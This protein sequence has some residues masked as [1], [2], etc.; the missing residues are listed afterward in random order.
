MGKIIDINLFINDLHDRDIELI[1]LDKFIPFNQKGQTCKL[2]AG[3][4]IQNYLYVSKFNSME[5][6]P[7]HK[8]RQTFN[9]SL[10]QRAKELIDSKVGEVYG[11]EQVKKVFEYNRFEV[12]SFRIYE[13]I[14]YINLIRDSLKN[15]CPVIVFF[16]V[17]P[18]RE[19]IQNNGSPSLLNGR[20]E[21]AAVVVGIYKENDEYR[22][23]YSQW[24]GFYE[25]SV[26]DLFK[27]TSQLKIDKNSED[28]KKFD[29]IPF[30][31][32][33]SAWISDQ[34]V[35]DTLEIFYEDMPVKKFLFSTLHTFF[36]SRISD[37]LTRNRIANPPIGLEGSL[38][39]TVT[40]ITGDNMSRDFLYEYEDFLVR[41]DSS[42]LIEPNE[43]YFEDSLTL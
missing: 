19:E 12:N 29:P 30:V 43:N 28:Y 25:C 33:K 22:V 32:P 13:E 5:P 21:H 2:V 31:L 18:R 26:T 4:A 17:I 38:V 40:I 11:T 34:Q 9:Y 41:N 24:G 3:I 27:S 8:E 1:F 20:F 14:I 37:D 23:I 7:L 42:S 16:D 36:K 35:K 10:R 6:L 15:L 39:N